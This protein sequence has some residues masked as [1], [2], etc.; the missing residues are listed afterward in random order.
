MSFNDADLTE[1]TWLTKNYEFMDTFKPEPDEDDAFNSSQSSINSLNEIIQNKRQDYSS[2]WKQRQ[3]VKRLELKSQHH[4]RPPLTLNCLIYLAIQDSN[5][6]C[7]PVRDIY[8]WIES[9]FPYFKLSQSWK[10]SI[11]HNLT[12]NKYFKKMDRSELL[13]E[14]NTSRLSSTYWKI[15]PD[16]KLYLNNMIQRSLIKYDDTCNENSMTALPLAQQNSDL[17]IEVASTLVRMK[18]L[19]ENRD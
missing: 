8:D 3:K 15:N 13:T 12:V 17:E 7:L 18:S 10:S 19:I 6:K 16:C 5:Q 9:R 14:S 11:R 4:T 1:L 2:I